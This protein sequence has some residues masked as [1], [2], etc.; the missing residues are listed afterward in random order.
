MQ[1]CEKRQYDNLRNNNCVDYI[2][3]FVIFGETIKIQL[4]F[5]RNVT[6]ISIES[7]ELKNILYA[8]TFI[9]GLRLTF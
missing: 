6:K 9:F 8:I 7:F 3:L 5:K 1:Y 4:I 2:F